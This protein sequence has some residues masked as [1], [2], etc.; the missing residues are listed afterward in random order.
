MSDIIG[1]RNTSNL[2]VLRCIVVCVCPSIVSY[3]RVGCEGSKRWVEAE[4]SELE[5]SLMGREEV[6]D[7]TQQVNEVYPIAP[8]AQISYGKGGGQGQNSTSQWSISNR[9]S[10]ANLLWEG[11]RSRTEL[12]QLME[13]I[14]SLQQRK[15][16]ME[17]GEVK[18]RIQQG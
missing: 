1:D 13:Y 14:Q 10:S 8:A 15:S 12:N 11:G 5:D 17:R 9:S 18:N 16:L 3:D 2:G 4:E 6:K 7:R